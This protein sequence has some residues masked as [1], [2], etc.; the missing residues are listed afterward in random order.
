MLTAVV[1]FRRSAA[2]PA[3]ALASLLPGLLEPTLI[4]GLHGSSSADAPLGSQ[5]WA[6]VSHPHG[7]ADAGK[8]RPT[9]VQRALSRAC[10]SEVCQ[11]TTASLTFLRRAAGNPRGSGKKRRAARHRSSSS[12]Q[13]DTDYEPG[14][15][16]QRPRKWKCLPG[17]VVKHKS[18]GRTRLTLAG[19]ATTIGKLLPPPLDHNRPRALDTASPS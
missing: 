19:T 4:A 15:K 9:L 10:R 13:D 5:E 7:S 18:P 3:G 17:L 8:P 12:L 14:L 1:S 11:L 2:I 16:V 6:E